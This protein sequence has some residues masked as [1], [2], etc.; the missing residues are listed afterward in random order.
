MANK[1]KEYYKPGPMTEGKRNIIQG[2][3]QE[4]NI[5][6]AADIQEALKDLLGSTIKEMMEAEMDDHLGYFN[7]R[8]CSLEVD[9]VRID[10]MF[11]LDFLLR[12]AN[13]RKS[14][15]EWLLRFLTGTI[16]S[17]IRSAAIVHKVF[18]VCKQKTFK[19]MHADK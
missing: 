12:F 8:A 1:K 9:A 7:P 14:Q 2:L 6:S 10:M 19:T 11:H 3:L 15:E 13:L 17:F 16:Q 5:E 4:Y 18:K